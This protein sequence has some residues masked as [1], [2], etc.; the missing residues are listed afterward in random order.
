MSGAASRLE[1]SLGWDVGGWN[2]D[3]NPKSRDAVVI[4]DAAGD[5]VGRPWRGNLRTVINE[6]ATSRDWLR[7]LFALCGADL[8]A[9]T[10]DAVLAID[11]PL[12]FSEAFARL[13]T[14]QGYEEPIGSSATNPY[15]FRKTEQILFESGLAPLSSIKD[16]IGSQTTKG[17]HVLAKFAPTV[18]G[19]GVWTDASTLTAIEAYPSACKRSPTMQAQWERVATSAADDPATRG[20]PKAFTHEDEHDALMCA[21]VAHAFR[22]DPDA[23]AQPPGSIPESEGWIWVPADVLTPNLSG[24]APRFQ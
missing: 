22:T 4:L 23:L 6:A 15:L 7:A 11:T 18:A 21:V 24:R 17:M 8:P 16:M 9:A 5:L 13:A 14:R 2:C 1:F 10:I 20:R 19:C 3:K 12:G